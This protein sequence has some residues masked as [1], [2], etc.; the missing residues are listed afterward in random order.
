M[1]RCPGAAPAETA[2]IRIDAAHTVHTMAGGMGASW[3]ALGPTVYWYEDLL[4]PGRNNRTSR[5]SAFGGN[6]PLSYTKAWDDLIGHARW[7]GLDLCR[8]EIDM[9]TYE[10]D[11]GRF[12]WESTEMKTLY[13]ILGHCQRSGVDV[14][15]TQLWQDVAWNAH[16]G[17]NRLESAPQSVPDFAE[18]LGTLLQHLVKHRGYHC[19]RWL[20][21]TNEPGGGWTWWRGPDKKC[22]SLMPAIRA[23]RAELDRRG[24]KDVAIAAPDSFNLTIAGCEPEDPAI[25]AFALHDYGGEV[26]AALFKQVAQTARA[27]GVPFLLAEFGHAFVKESQGV[28]IPFGDFTSEIPKSYR[29]QLLNA[30]KAIVGLNAGVDGL[31]RWSFVN[32][33]DLDGQWQLIRTWNP[34]SWEYCKDVCA[35]PVPYYGYGILTRFTAKHSHILEVQGNSEQTKAAALRS[36]KGNLTI[37]VLNKAG[38]ERNVSLSVIGLRVGCTVYKYQVTE[39]AVGRFDFRM[40]PLQAFTISPAR[41]EIGECE[42]AQSIT[43]YSTYKLVHADPGIIAED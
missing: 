36:P 22:A 34:K 30:E 1:G 16:R 27:R 9:R 13:R 21:V 37:M 7:L 43:V 5:G 32:R 23:V 33:G 19:I 6:P 24:L 40:E 3:H 35:E 38:N 14:L 41:T 29:A 42:P 10:P 25:G 20:S 15:F 11:R 12:D 26:P 2:A 28:T 31:N 8:V 17:I 4:G 18:G 39:A